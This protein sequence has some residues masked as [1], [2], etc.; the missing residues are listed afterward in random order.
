MPDM[1]VLDTKLEGVKL[2]EPKVFG[3]S[4]GFF[5]ES[6][7]AQQFEAAGLPTDFV[8][9][10]HSHSARG[11]V[12]GLHF[13]VKRPQGKLVRVLYG[14]VYDVVLDLRKDSPTYG[15]WEGFLLDD[16]KHQQLWIPKGFAHG[17]SVLSEFAGFFYKV[18]DF[19]QPGDEGGVAYN[20][21][22]LA[23]DWQVEAPIVSE[24]DQNLPPLSQLEQF[25]QAGETA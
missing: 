23:I 3:D 15:Q 16:K 2:I 17:F 8:Q 5:L 19:W 24:K 1:E 25:P 21:P 12:R 6:Y 11:V 14:Q 9:D 18:D 7:N 22:D 20:D 4:R 13:Q 10:N